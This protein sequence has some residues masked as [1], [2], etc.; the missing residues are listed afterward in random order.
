MTAPVCFGGGFGGAPFS[1]GSGRATPKTPDFPAFL[2]S[3]LPRADRL[4]RADQHHD[5]QHQA[6]P[7]PTHEQDFDAQ[8]QHQRL[9]P[10]QATGQPEADG[11]TEDVSYRVG[12]RVSLVALGGLCVPFSLWMSASSRRWLGQARPDHIAVRRY[13][14]VANQTSA[15]TTNTRNP[16][17]IPHPTAG[18][19]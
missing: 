15:A 18:G 12:D 7:N 2:P 17:R 13:S 14:R 5:V 16:R 19:K 3:G 10:S 4:E 11:A 6:I 9:P 8:E 1:Q